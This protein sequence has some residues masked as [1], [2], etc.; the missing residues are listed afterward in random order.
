[1]NSR[2]ISVPE[3][4]NVSDNNYLQL[5]AIAALLNGTKSQFNVTWDG[6]YAVIDT[7]AP[8]TGSTT[9][10]K[11]TATD[12]V[13]PSNTRFMVDGSLVAFEKAYLIEGDT[14]YLQFREV[15]EKLSGTE[16][17]FNIYWDELIMRAVIEPGKAY[18]G[19]GGTSGTSDTGGT[20][21]TSGTS[22]TGGTGGTSGT[23]GTSDTPTPTDG[24]AGMYIGDSRDAVNLVLD[25]PYRSISDSAGDISFYGSYDHFTLVRFVNDACTFIYTTTDIGGTGN[26]T[27]YQDKDDG[28]AQYAVSV[29]RL[30]ALDVNTNE[31]IIFELSNMFRAR[32]GVDALAWNDQLA[33]AAHL[34]A[35]DMAARSYFDHVTPEGLSLRDRIVNAGYE[36][37]YTG[38]ENIGADFSNGV[39][40]VGGWINSSGHRRNILSSS[41]RELGTGWAANGS[42]YQSYGVQCFGAS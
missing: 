30:G 36:D 5:R 6:T 35:E 33:T 3:A 13:R 37:L 34:H 28:D 22:G 21:G 14:N 27:S 32:H 23:S 9:A 4:Y 10:A 15:G 25:T 40:A 39:T 41:F 42:A 8:Y 19:T 7:G 1:M 16:S 31:Q 2:A 12:N 17:Q 38:G 11:L 20:G 26:V 29:G 18:T 24:L